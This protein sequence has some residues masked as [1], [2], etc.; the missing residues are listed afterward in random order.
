MAVAFRDKSW[1]DNNHSLFPRHRDSLWA[2]DDWM[3]RMND[4]PT[5][6]PRPRDIMSRFFKDTERWWDDWPRDWPKMDA[7]M[8]RFTSHLDRL[9]NNWRQDPFWKDLYPQ[10]AEP[11]FKEGI[12]VNSSITN[13][14]RK[15]AVAIDAYQF[16]PEEIQVKTLDD[17]LLVEGRHEEMRDRD[18]FTKMY[19]VRKYQLPN[20]VNPMDITSNIDQKGRLTVEASKKAQALTG[21]ERLIPIEGSSKYRSQSRTRHD[22]GYSNGYSHS[23]ASNP[24]QYSPVEVDT[25][26]GT[27]RYRSEGSGGY[28]QQQ[29]YRSSSRQ[30]YSSNG[31]HG[32]QGRTVEIPINRERSYDRS[33]S[34]GVGGLRE[35][36]LRR[37]EELGDRNGGRSGDH[38]H[39][40]SYYRHETRSSG[41]GLSPHQVT[42][43]NENRSYTNGRRASFETNGFR[44]QS[45]DTD[46]S[47]FHRGYQSGY[48][49]AHSGNDTSQRSGNYRVDSPASTSTGGILKRSD[50]LPPRAESRSE[51]VRS[52]K[53]VRTYN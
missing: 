23:P 19:F 46:Q 17:T 36:V 45:R 49:A 28:R 48:Q 13:D 35:N 30:D 2:R 10:W 43:S 5:E 1:M 42:A 27:D 44:S 38:Q 31:N 50:D 12:D 6:W 24:R 20:D 34:K 53:I 9:D 32:N 3:D 33:D 7:I 37:E 39:S 21:R 26:S 16:R 51:S 18:N 29:E 14:D 15:F 47:A 25:G 41:G 4:W 11:I 22:S 8:P 52:V 40:E